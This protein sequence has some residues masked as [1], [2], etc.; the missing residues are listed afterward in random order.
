MYTKIELLP[1]DVAHPDLDSD[2][3]RPGPSPGADPIA[4]PIARC[5]CSCCSVSFFVA[6]LTLSLQ[7]L[8]SFLVS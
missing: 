4:D 2:P 8:L 6:S 1:V 3:L 5:R 7:D